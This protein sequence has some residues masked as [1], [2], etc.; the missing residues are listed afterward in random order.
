MKN[1]SRPVSDESFIEELQAFAAGDVRTFRAGEIIFSSGDW[2]DGIYL[3][4]TG[5]VRITA[6]L[7]NNASRTLATFHPGDFF[8]EMSVIDDAPRSATAQAETDTQA[9]FLGREEL[10]RMLEQNPHLALNLVREFSK[11]MRA[12][13]QKYLD[14]VVQAERLAAVGRF[15]A[16]IVHDFKNPLA[17]IRLAADVVS[18]HGSQP[19]LRDKMAAGITQQVDQ[20]TSMLEELIEFIRPSGAEIGLARASF[21]QFMDPLV[22]ELRREISGRGVELEIADPPPPVPVR[23]DSRRLTRVLHNLVHNAAEAM[24]GGGKII[25]RFAASDD[26]LRLEVED[27]GPGIDPRIADRLFEPFATYG[28]EQGTGLGLSICKRIVEDHGGR[29]FAGRG[30]SGGALF[31]IVLPIDFVVGTPLPAP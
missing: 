1:P 13:N 25:L 14:E 16:T 18:D 30:R 26:V 21:A 10:L 4:K 24:P 29:I 28:K 5:R 7:D 27:T 3:I 19:P 23:L 17:I 6:V 11:R 20:M 15:A 2:G 9:L 8:G 31:S 22:L 12:L